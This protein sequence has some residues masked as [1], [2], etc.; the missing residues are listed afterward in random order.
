MKTNIFLKSEL[1]QFC[2][3]SFRS[4]LIYIFDFLDFCFF[5]MKQFL[6]GRSCFHFWP[7]GNT[8]PSSFVEIIRSEKPK[9]QK[10]EN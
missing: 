3:S 8:P 4:K 7:W 2:M 6:F 5:L 10:R 1:K 9:Q